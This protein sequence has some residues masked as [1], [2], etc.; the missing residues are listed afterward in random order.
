[1]DLPMYR[2]YMDKVMTAVVKYTGRAGVARY[3]RSTP[4]GVNFCFDSE[5]LCCALP[6]QTP[7]S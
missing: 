7:S 6:L 2:Y 3:P 4:D 5:A 1:M